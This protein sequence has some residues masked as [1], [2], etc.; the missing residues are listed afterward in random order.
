MVLSFLWLMV[1]EPHEPDQVQPRS[2][3]KINN[4]GIGIPNN[5]NNTHPTFPSC[6]RP[7]DFLIRFIRY[8]RTAWLSFKLGSLTH[9]PNLLRC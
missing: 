7:I 6:R 4:T 3:N 8:S 1:G 2:R 5:H 9:R